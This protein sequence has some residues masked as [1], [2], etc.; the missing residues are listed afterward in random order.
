MLSI[1]GKLLIAMGILLVIVGLVFLW[2]PK[3]HLRYHKSYSYPGSH[4][5]FREKIDR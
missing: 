2:G 5:A 3:V 1:M 4:P